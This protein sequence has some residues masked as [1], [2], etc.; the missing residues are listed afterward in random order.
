MSVMRPVHFEPPGFSGHALLDSGGGEKLERIGGVSLRRP[1]PQ[2][3]W[4][5]RLDPEAW[6]AA[7][8]CFERDPESGGKGG[9]WRPGPRAAG[10]LR[11]ESPE[12]P[13]TFGEATFLIRPTSFKHVG[14]F[15]EQATNWQLLADLAPQLE[16]PRLLNLFG[17]SGAASVV[18]RLAGYEVT[19]VDASKAAISWTRDNARA[20]GLSDDGLRVICDDALA[21]ARREVRRGNRY[22]A[23]LLDPPHY[24][25]GPKNE[26]WRLEESL[27][28]LLDTVRQLVDEVGLVVLSTYAVGY[29][30]LAFLNLF[31]QWADGSATAGELVLR[32]GEQPGAPA[33]LL[34]AG[35]CARWARGVELS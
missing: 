20:S 19:H 18:A 12:W 23:I 21:F 14:L 34:P 22:S 7:D 27:A 4:A 9:R 24:G 35:F 5:P 11:G 13:C 32:E 2:A 26:T 10:F 3:L 31:D 17:Y 25:R 16:R 8:L 33:R 29:S 30:P 1:D 28:P 6:E 15:P